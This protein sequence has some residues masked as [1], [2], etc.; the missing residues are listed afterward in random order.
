MDGDFAP[1]GAICEL[2]RRH[3]ALTYC[4]TVPYAVGFTDATGPASPNATGFRTHVDVIGRNISEKPT[5]VWAAIRRK[6]AG[7]PTAVLRS[8]APG[9]I[10]LTALP[11]PVCTAALAATRHLRSFG[12]TNVALSG[13]RAPGSSA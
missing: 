9:F 1:V 7:P 13:E 10:F 2:A 6:Q 5:A 8:Y 12:P 3:N 11:S 4:G